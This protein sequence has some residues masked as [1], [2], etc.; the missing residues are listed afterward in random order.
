MKLLSLVAAS[1]LCM[2]VGIG[3]GVA[4]AQATAEIPVET[5]FKKSEYGQLTFSPDQKFM[6]A[7]VPVNS[8][9]NLII[10]DLD[11]RSATRVT[12][13]DK[14]DVL[15]FWW[16]TNDRLLFVTGD[17]EQ[18]TRNA[19]DG[20]L[21]AVDKD[22]KNAKILVQPITAT[23]G[24]AVLRQTSYAGRVKD[25]KDEVLVTAND[26]DA[27]TSDIYRMN[28]FTG[29]KTLV[30]FDSPGK[31]A[32]WTLDRDNVARVA[33]TEDRKKSVWT[34][35]YRAGDKGPFKTLRTWNH[36]L[37]EV[38]IPIQFD[39]DNK[40]MIVASNIGR[41]TM[42]FFWFDPEANKLG[43]LIYGDD[44]YDVYSTLL[45]GSPLG[46]GG[47]LLFSGREEDPGKIIGVSYFADKPKRVWFDE[48]I[49]KTQTMLDAALTPGNFNTWNPNQRRT[50]VFSRSD[51][52]P[53][54]YF[55]FDQ[56]KKTIEDTGVKPSKW[57][58][59]KQMRPMQYVTW[60]ATDG[61][62]IGGYLTLPA[63]YKKGS[64][65]P[66]I[67]HPHGG[68]WAKDN[69]EFSREVQFMANRGYAVLQPNFRGSTGYGTKHLKASYKQWGDAMIDD[70]LAGVDWAIKEGYADKDKIAAYGASYGGY[71]TLM[72]LVKRPDMFKWGVNY[73]GVT[74][75]IVHQDTQ[76]AQRYGDFG[77]SL[78]KIVNGDQK[79][80]REMFERTSP[81]RHVSKI[82]APVFHAYG[83]EDRNVDIENGRVIRSAF[84]KASK[85]QEW[86][87]VAEEAHGY[88]LD[89]NVFDFYNRFDAFMKK[90]LPITK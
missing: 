4:H 88:R 52:D 56:D 65:V 26:R 87:Y 9:F 25:S 44:R 48:E 53:G 74:D 86:M 55:V 29:R 17:R 38:V 13:F 63:S 62:K 60:T 58:D 59:A 51:V 34:F 36:E 89:K 31:V 24:Q 80:D 6:A 46:E 32:D 72:A 67:L 49:K 28:I 2:L 21:F 16:A 11:K 45:I 8:R 68:P 90:H 76:P 70:M 78:A 10:L 30:S 84:D 3:G 41:D 64:P 66:L 18:F 81:A 14:A 5:L 71:A 43:D 85:P 79:A 61:M 47:R 20:G 50:L 77:E 42:A 19:G 27:G 35:E 22:G 82:K 69:W 40:R 54:S 83:G 23:P 12:S 33:L 1:T 15:N 7:V 39:V 37:K 75:M 73:V 57:I